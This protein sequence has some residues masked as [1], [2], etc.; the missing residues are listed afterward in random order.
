MTK[1]IFIFLITSIIYLLSATMQNSNDEIILENAD[2]LIGTTFDNLSFREFYSNVKLKH[3]DVIVKCNYAK[4]FIEQ[5]KADLLGNVRIN[6][7]TMLL[8]SPR[9]HYDGNLGFAYAYDS[10]S[11]IDLK[12][13]LSA[14]EGTY[15]V[16]NYI[17][18]FLVDVEIEDDSV[19]IF[20]DRI[21][22]NRKNRIS[23]AYGDVVIKGKFTDVIITADT[24][25]TNPNENYSIAFGEPILFK[26]D[27]TFTEDSLDIEN[28]IM[29]F[30]TLTITSDTMESFREP[31]NEYYKFTQNVEI[32]KGDIIAKSMEAIYTKDLIIL[33][34]KPIVWYGETQ[35]FAD[36]III[37]LENNNLKN[38]YTYNNSIMVTRHDSTDK[39]RYNQISGVDIIID[40]DSS[41]IVGMTAIGEAKSLYYFMDDNENNGVDRKST[42][43]IRVKFDGGEVDKIY[44]VGMTVGEFFPENLVFDEPPKFNLPLFKWNENRP[45]RKNLLLRSNVKQ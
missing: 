10:V 11:I 43:T 2:S 36:S 41:Q 25:V 14:N 30:D 26:I 45:K 8:Q 37:K 20:A 5:N 32:V 16:K 34:N 29:I 40:I 33:K 15:D 19:K 35:L 13:K 28:Q 24:I 23:K 4:Q 27:T 9:I 22:Y 3:R 39:E 17:A 6:Q 1:Y 21:I 42:D 31:Y 18:D 38:I 44:W 12:T 7:N